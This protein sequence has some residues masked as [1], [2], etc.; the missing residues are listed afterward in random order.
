MHDAA[1]S[2]SSTSYMLDLDHDAGRDHPPTFTIDARRCGNV[3]RFINH[4]VWW[5]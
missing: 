1:Q 3:A 4:S 5:I 2:S